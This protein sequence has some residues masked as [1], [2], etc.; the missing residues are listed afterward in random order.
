[1]IKVENIEV[2]NFEG[3]IRGM[4]NPMNSWNKSDSKWVGTQF[5]RY[6]V[7]KN[8]LDLMRRLYRAGKE[9]AKYLRQIF[10]SMDITAPL[11]WWKQADQYRIN[12]TTNSCSTMHTIHKKKFELED[13]SYDNMGLLGEGLLKV[14][15]ENLNDL[16]EKYINEKDNPLLKKDYWNTMI[17]LLPSSYNQRRTITM[18][19]ENVVNIIKQRTGHK[20]AEWDMFVAILWDLPYI[21]E[22]CQKNS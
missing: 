11:Y 5:Q 2:Y 12:V 9:N 3:A 20:L 15:I 4:R 10:V 6:E 1:M 21:K 14:T 17:K 18:N 16:R 8:D 7:G 19:Y 22:I 13:F